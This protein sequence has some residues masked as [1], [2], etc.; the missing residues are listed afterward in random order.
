MWIENNV[1]GKGCAGY[2]KQTLKN[3]DVRSDD[4]HKK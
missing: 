3:R 4:Y 1:D 2:F